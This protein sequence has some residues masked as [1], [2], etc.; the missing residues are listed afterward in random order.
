MKRTRWLTRLSCG[1]VGL[2]LALGLSS[3]A[4]EPAAY[5]PQAWIDYPSGETPI[6]L[7]TEVAVI[8]HGFAHEGVAEV[9]LSV[10]GEPYRRDAPPEAGT[11]FVSLRQV[12]I[13][14]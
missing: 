5:Y 11:D 14:T 2:S 8:S 10:N 3:C 12:W 6:Q 1:L 4:E 13:P 7:G 9:V